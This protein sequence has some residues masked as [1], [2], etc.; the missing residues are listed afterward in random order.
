M[1]DQEVAAILTTHLRGKPEIWHQ[2]AHV[3]MY[4][5]LIARC[6]Q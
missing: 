6:P 5:A 4:Q 3:A 2:G 1:T